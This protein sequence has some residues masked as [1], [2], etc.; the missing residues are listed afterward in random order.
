MSVQSAPA[1]SP[2]PPPL[3]S[4]P[5]PAIVDPPAFSSFVHLLSTSSTDLTSLVQTLYTAAIYSTDANTRQSA[6]DLLSDHTALQQRLRSAEKLA[7]GKWILHTPPSSS[8]HPAP[9]ASTSSSSSSSHSSDGSE[10]TMLGTLT[11]SALTAS[12][13][14]GS[15]TFSLTSSYSLVSRS[16]NQQNTKLD[17]RGHMHLSFT[18]VLTPS[19]AVMDDA[20][21]G[22][23]RDKGRVEGVLDVA[24][25]ADGERMKGDFVLSEE[26][27]GVD[28]VEGDI[29]EF[30]G[31]KANR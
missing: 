5:L 8:L 3:S 27:A 20:P 16:H 15:L 25:S 13:V 12:H 29:T 23:G 19:R 4:S 26:R 9:G 10:D 28:D 21:A 17:A 6:I 11:I 14:S 7:I 18:V 30:V 31:V 1:P 22:R 2:S 24:I